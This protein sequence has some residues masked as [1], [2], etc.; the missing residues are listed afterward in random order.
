MNDFMREREGGGG[1]EVDVVEVNQRVMRASK[2]K[3]FVAFKN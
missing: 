2:K 3:T 1:G